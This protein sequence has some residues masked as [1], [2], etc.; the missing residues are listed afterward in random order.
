MDVPV[1]QIDEYW[2]YTNALLWC[3]GSHVPAHTLQALPAW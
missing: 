2:V 1:L 3:E